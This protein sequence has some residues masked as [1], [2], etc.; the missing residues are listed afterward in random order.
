MNK[1]TKLIVGALIV[2]LIIVILI[3]GIAPKEDKINGNTTKENSE[4]ITP[5]IP[6]PEDTEEVDGI[7]CT[8]NT[9]NC[10]DFTVCEEVIDIFDACPTDVH[11]LD[12]DGDGI[13]CERLCK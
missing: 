1:I 2:F 10:G 13:P 12:K 5:P 8:A 4:I 11:K 7:N 9:Y 6:Q 3:Y